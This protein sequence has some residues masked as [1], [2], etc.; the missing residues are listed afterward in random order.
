MPQHDH[1]LQSMRSHQPSAPVQ[2]ER[3]QTLN[4]PPDPMART[5]ARA[6][7]PPS[8]LHAHNVARRPRGERNAVAG[9]PSCTLATGR[10]HEDLPRRPG[11]R[12]RG[13]G[14]ARERRVAR[15]AGVNRGCVR[16]FARVFSVERGADGGRGFARRALWLLARRRR[17]ATLGFPDVRHPPKIR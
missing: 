5:S 3:I 2:M 12:R 6:P 7:H 11:R 13:G 9:P 1:Q 4:V 15:H 8:T 17:R 16:R 10:A 14:C